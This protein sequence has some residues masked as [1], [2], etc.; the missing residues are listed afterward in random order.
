ML[1]SRLPY[2]LQRWPV[3]VTAQALRESASEFVITQV[4]RRQFFVQP[5]NTAKF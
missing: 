2:W 4:A 5:A 1:F 3:A